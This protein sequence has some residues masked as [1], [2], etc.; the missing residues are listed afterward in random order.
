MGTLGPSFCN[1]SLPFNSQSIFGIQDKLNEYWN[2]LEL[3]DIN[4]A[5]NS[6]TNASNTTTL[7]NKKS[8]WFHE[9]EK[10]GTCA[11]SLPA[12][13]SEFKYFFQGLEW[14]EKYNMKDVL[15]KGGIKLNSTLY[16]ADYWK[17][18]K[19]VLNKNAWI[20]CNF[21]HVSWKNKK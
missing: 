3:Q 8:I 6:S 17:A 4:F 20:E 11:I 15:E 21:K 16:V 13:D 1:N 10:H 5:D 18:V 2:D 12:L 9:W 7:E 19:S 14:S